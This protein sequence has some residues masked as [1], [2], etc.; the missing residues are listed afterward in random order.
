MI[1]IDLLALA[2]AC[3]IVITI[4]NGGGEM[5]PRAIND[6]FSDIERKGRTAECMARLRYDLRR[7]E[8]G[9]CLWAGCKEMMAGGRYCAGHRERINKRQNERYARVKKLKGD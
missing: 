6:S 5:S 1:T 2:I 4:F 3:F 7:M 8:S 9:L